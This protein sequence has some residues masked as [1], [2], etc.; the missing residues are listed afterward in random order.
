MLK[1]FEEQT[2]ELS[3][4]EKKVI[5]PILIRG[6]QNKVGK[7]RCITNKEICNTLNTEMNLQVKL[8]EPRIRKC[9]YYCRSNNLIPRLIATSK[10]YWIATDKQELIDWANTIQGRINAIQETLSYANKQVLEWDNPCDN[11]KTLF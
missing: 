10:G 1:G 9:I 2:N 6:F 3:D 8:N 11:Q 5:V 4:Y 7:E